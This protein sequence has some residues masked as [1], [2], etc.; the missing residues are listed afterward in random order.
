MYNYDMEKCWKFLRENVSYVVLSAFFLF[1]LLNPIFKKYDYGGGFPLILAFC[2]LLAVIAFFE[3]RKKREIAFAEK[4]FLLVFTLFVV[5]SFVFSQTKNLGFSEVL[6]FSSM[7]PF[8]FIFAHKKNK[9]AGNFL[10][11]VGIGTILAVLLGYFLYFSQP[12][13]RMVGSFF[14]IQYHAHVWPNA[15]ALLLL[16]AWPVYL[17][18]VTK[19]TKWQAALVIGFLFSALLLTFSRGALIALLGQVLLLLIYFAKRIRWETVFLIFLTLLTA[20]FF[21]YG[22]NSIRAVSHEVLDV[23]ERVTFDNEESL[24]SKQERVDFWVGAVELALKK[25]VFGWGPYSFRHAYNVRQET[26]LGSADHPHNVFLKIAAENGLIALGAFLAFLLAVFLTVLKRFPGLSKARKDTVF[27]LGVSV[28]GAF[29][30][31]LIDYNLNFTANLLLI[32]ILIIF[33]RS[34]VVKRFIKLRNAVC[35]L[36]LAL[37]AGI[38]SL[39]EGTLLVLSEV[40]DESYLEYSFFP[41][42]YYLNSADTATQN[43][44][45]DKAV[46][47]IETEISLNPLD[48]RA[49]HLYGV[50]NCQKGNMSA[51]MGNFEKAIL[52]NPMNDFGYYRDYFRAVQNFPDENIDKYL[53]KVL[54]MLETYFEYVENNVHFTAY[55]SNVEAAAGLVEELSPF[56]SKEKAEELRIKKEKMLKTAEKMRSEKTF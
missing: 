55:T 37:F 43:G 14:N 3:F 54:P 23:K 13:V 25:P 26:L 41:R 15:F 45:F 34:L 11:I 10:R 30:H 32:F 27:I 21:F 12:E 53:E 20:L 44:R 7:V 29:A 31:N 52:L 35:G 2:V 5:L 22:S 24:T 19:N 1:A 33:I 16:M 49:W 42:N 47:Y 4:V 36:I 28:L 18:F 50:V 46:D 38:F 8:Y 39:Y 40:L 6:A 48:S 51:C 9:W 56:I 17:L